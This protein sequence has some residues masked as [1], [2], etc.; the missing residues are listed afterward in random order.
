MRVCADTGLSLTD[1][2]LTGYRIAKSSYG[3][4]DPKPRDGSL[5]G[6]TS[7][8]RFDT[9]GRTIYLAETRRTAFAETLSPA[10]VGPAFNSAVEFAAHHFGIS[11]ALAREEI[12]EEWTRNGNLVPGWLPAS[13]RD[14]RRMYQLTVHPSA[15]E[16][17]DLTQAESIAALNRNITD[18][19]LPQLNIDEI[20]LGTLTG[21]NRLATTLIAE[22]LR[23]QV[24]DDG[25]YAAGVKFHSKLG[26]GACWA[27]WM[28]HTDDGL[29]SEPVTE[30]DQQDI[31][32][33]DTDLTYILNLYGAQCR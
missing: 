22:W 14:G 19:L 2:G 11:A 32:H 1:P 29:G 5:V 10:R 8:S 9:P 28:R 23:N 13:W 24:L 30:L 6:R 16:W 17:I 18:I 12:E 20:T 31:T 15:G 7:W 4:L 33:D 27:Y 26:S 21:P 3:A 25:N